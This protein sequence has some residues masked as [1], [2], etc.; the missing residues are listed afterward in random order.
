MLPN[1][2]FSQPLVVMQHDMFCSFLLL[3]LLHLPVN[4]AASFR[5]SKDHSNKRQLQLQPAQNK[6][7]EQ[8]QILSTC[9]FQLGVMCLR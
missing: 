2:P 9:H 5:A 3:C 8:R 1:G 6:Y 4:R 7:L